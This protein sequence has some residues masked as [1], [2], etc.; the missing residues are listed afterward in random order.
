MER[1][2]SEQD[3]LAR[4]IAGDRSALERLLLTHYERLHAR[5][6]RRLPAAVQGILAPEDILQQAFVSVFQGISSFE[7][8]GPHS[9]FRWVSGISE[10]RLQDAIRAH[11]AAKRGGG[12]SPLQ[13]ARADN[14]GSEV[15]LLALLAGPERTPS[16][17]AARREAAGAVHVAMAALKDDYRE[18]IRLRYI[19]GLSVREIA[20][21]MK[22]SESSVHHL[23]SRALSELRVVMGRSS[24]YLTRK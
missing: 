13:R 8:R 2:E 15:C 16:R 10:N 5:I 17:T 20:Q 21:A 6:R 23:C 18:A 19:D 22:R 9:F 1:G 4:A 3:V 14:G 12:R 11:R 24:Q 7:P